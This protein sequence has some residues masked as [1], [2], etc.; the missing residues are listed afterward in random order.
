MKFDGSEFER[1]ERFEDSQIAPLSFIQAPAAL[2]SA[3]YKNYVKR[4]IDLLV[5][6]L[7]APIAIPVT[8]GLIVLIR[9]DGSSSF[10]GQERIGKDGKI[11]NCWKLRSMI[12]DADKKLENYLSQYPEAREEWDEFQKLRNDPRITPI[13]RFMRRTSL[14]ELPQLWCVFKGEMSIVGP[15][16]FLPQQ[17]K[18]YSGQKYYEMRPGITG[19]WQVSFTLSLNRFLKNKAP[20]SSTRSEAVA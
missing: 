16:P 8:L 10:Y 4:L 19:L 5:V 17:Q 6:F 1:R 20:F 9:R 2:R 7:A 3:F 15:R 14:D 12:P 13:G 18:L 11:F